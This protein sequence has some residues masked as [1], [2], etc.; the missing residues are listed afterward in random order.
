LNISSP[1]TRVI[2]YCCKDL[3]EGGGKDRLAIT[4]VRWAESSRRRNSH[5]M[6][7]T[8]GKNK[9]LFNDNDNNSK[10][11]EICAAK[12]KRVL[13]PIVEWEESDVW[14]Y[15]KQRG[16]KYCSLYDEGFRRLGCIGCPMARRGGRLKEFAR[17]PKFY[18][19]YLRAFD[20]M[21]KTNINKK[22]CAASV[23]KTAEDVMKWWIYEMPND[24]NQI[25]LFD[26][27]AI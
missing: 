26:D 24:P 21:L 25:S 15:I 20:R 14:S 4:G 17:W 1:P 12:S 9:I 22:G 19:A 5:A 11:L 2:R 23:W 13:N 3:K 18:D 16:L 7:E 6:F 27:E 8:M 10:M